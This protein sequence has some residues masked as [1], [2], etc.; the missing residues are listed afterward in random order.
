[1]F[2]GCADGKIAFAAYADPECRE[3]GGSGK[4][5]LMTCEPYSEG[6]ANGENG[7]RYNSFYSTSCV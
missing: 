5:P 4:A 2:S 1:M 7:Y 6:S 3:I